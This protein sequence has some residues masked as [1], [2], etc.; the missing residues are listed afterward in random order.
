MARTATALQAKESITLYRT[1]AVFKAEW[2]DIAS[3]DFEEAGDHGPPF[4]AISLKDNP[5][6]ALAKITQDYQG[7]IFL[8]AIN[9]VIV[10]DNVRIQDPINRGGLTFLDVT[11]EI[12]GLKDVSGTQ[13]L[14][15]ETHE[16]VVVVLMPVSAKI[17][18]SV[19]DISESVIARNMLR[20][21]PKDE[22]Q[23][24]LMKAFNAERAGQWAVARGKRLISV[25]A[26]L[27]SQ[28]DGAWVLSFPAG[29]GKA[30]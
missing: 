25:D 24:S 22:A 7:E 28:G 5:A 1:P 4:L 2:Q 23:L 3:L 13:G 8:G 10:S 19:S 12:F 15:P 20:F 6:R 11:P 29:E 14:G 17:D 26:G 30:D 21:R 18:I 16:R 27:S 9:Q